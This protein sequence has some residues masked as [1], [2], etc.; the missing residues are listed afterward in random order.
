MSEDVKRKIDELGRIIIPL[1][2]R[3]ALGWNDDTEISV[4][5]EGE[6]LILQTYQGGC[7]LC[8]NKKYVRL[9]HG[10]FVCQKCI[11]ELKK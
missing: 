1:E 5:R 10:K 11:D 3:S 9:I 6:Q 7:L 8:G 4:S 2:M